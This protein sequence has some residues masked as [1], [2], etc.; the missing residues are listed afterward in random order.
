ME[1]AIAGK[2]LNENHPNHHPRYPLSRKPNRS[3]P[4]PIP[5]HEFTKTQTQ[6]LG[7]TSLPAHFPSPT[8]NLTKTSPHWELG[9][10][11]LIP[12]KSSGSGQTENPWCDTFQCLKQNYS[13]T[14]IPD[15]H[16]D[17]I[18][19]AGTTCDTLDISTKRL[20]YHRST[21]PSELLV[22]FFNTQAKHSAIPRQTSK[23][24]K[25]QSI[26]KSPYRPSYTTKFRDF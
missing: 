22:L 16:F 23:K 19:G 15:Y 3:Q 12:E 24:L 2:S 25:V 11:A 14:T 8:M 9:S 1:P 18:A 5:A 13:I 6:L 10:K 21:P 7:S 26:W 17:P 4:Q 20:W